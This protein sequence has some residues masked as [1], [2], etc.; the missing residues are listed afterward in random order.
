MNTNVTLKTIFAS[1]KDK[2]SAKLSGLSL[3]KDSQQVQEIVTDFLNDMFE[4][5]GQFR[6]NLTESEDYLLQAS[7]R[8]LQTHQNIALEFAK[9][10]KNALSPNGTRKS[11]PSSQDG[12]AP[13]IYMSAAGAG[14]GALAGGIIGTWGAIAGAIAGTALVIY[15]STR[16]TCKQ[17]SSDNG[18]MATIPSPSINVSTFCGIVESICDSIDGVIDTYR[19]QVKRI[20]NS[21]EQRE[22]PSLQNTYSLLTE[23]IA[24]VIKATKDDN[25]EIPSKLK[26]AISI[27]E[28]TLEN[29]D[30]KYVNGKI[31]TV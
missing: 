8:L 14:V 5:E 30:L 6:Q 21:Y 20:V 12:K 25:V 11:V 29:Y 15:C 31:V 23:Q 26:N 16:T 24:N 7:L 17:P 3:P 22:V 10:S 9:A 27:L 13:S 4:N 19:V 18:E 1:S 2:L 28:E